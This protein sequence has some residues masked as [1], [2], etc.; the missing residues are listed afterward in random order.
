MFQPYLTEHHYYV[1]FEDGRGMADVRNAKGLYRRLTGYDEQRYAGHGRWESSSGLSRA[2]DRDSYDDYREPTPAEIEQFRRRIDGERPEPP[3][4]VSSREKPEDGAF[5]VFQR[6][7]DMVDPR[8]AVAVVE[9]LSPEHRFTL[10]LAG[11]EW[12][13]LACEVALLSARRRAEPVE[14]HYYFAVFENLDDV[15]DVGR[16][17]SL[18]RCPAGS[19]GTWEMYLHDGTWV[20]GQEP[21]RQTVLPVGRADVERIGRGRD[22]AAV[23]YFDVWFRGAGKGGRRRHVLVRRTA[24]VD[25]TVDDLG[26]RPTDVLARLE[27]GCRVEELGERGFRNSRYVAAVTGR[28]PGYRSEQPRY[29]AVFRSQEDVYDLGNVLFLAKRLPNPYELEYELWTP[30]GW[31]PTGDMLLGY[32]TLPISEEEFQRL[33]AVL[34]HR[35]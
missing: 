3:L 6:E 25:E 1:L 29:Q 10:P 16:A 4:P 2:G 30:D 8:S 18:V 12:K 22:S 23:R 11:Y 5:A 33:A 7:A 20:R 24:S 13:S 14:G 31:Q 15:V 26:W 19:Q 21:Q 28:S 9:E 17:H 27:P 34:R 35:G 32:T